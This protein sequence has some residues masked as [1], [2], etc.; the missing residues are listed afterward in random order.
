MRLEKLL[1]ANCS[2]L[3]AEGEDVYAQALA[4]VPE[5]RADPIT[6]HEVFGRVEFINRQETLRS[7]PCH[8]AG[9][10]GFFCGRF[11]KQA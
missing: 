3:R 8:S 9:L 11:V 6:P 2:L 10:D 1:F 5:L 7:L 4:T